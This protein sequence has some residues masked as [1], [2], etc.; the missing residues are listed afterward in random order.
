MSNVKEEQFFVVQG[1]M[2][3]K[4]KLK[5]T[6]LVIYAIIYGF[7][8]E[9]GHWFNGSLQYL[10]DWTGVSKQSCITS[11]KKL[12]DAKLILKEEIVDKGVK[13]CRYSKNF[14]GIKDFLIRGY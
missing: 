6:D 5:G 9:E 14:N 3:S 13:Y 8:Q 2:R 1:W 7:S 10:S 4:L 12:V 11:L